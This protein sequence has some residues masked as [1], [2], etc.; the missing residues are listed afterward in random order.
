MSLLRNDDTMR[1]VGVRRCF[2]SRAAEE[3]VRERERRKEREREKR[4]ARKEREKRS[5]E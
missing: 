3:R 5:V 4:K 2:Q 1:E